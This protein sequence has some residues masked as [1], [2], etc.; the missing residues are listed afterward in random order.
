MIR[1]ISLLLFVGLVFSTTI[2]I[3]SDYTTIQAGINA[4][5]D[6]DTVLVAQGTYSENLI[7]EK[8][9]VIA[10]HAINDNLNSDWTNNENIQGTIINGVPE[11]SNPGFGSCLVIRDGNIAPI[12][13]GLTFQNGI[14]TNLIEIDACA[15]PIQRP[16]RPGGGTLIH[17]A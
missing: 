17:K 15:G 14:G 3:P 12:I 11:P 10:S 6:G 4:S 1:Y 16:D 7:L 2:N 13:I 5:M 9:I 8:E